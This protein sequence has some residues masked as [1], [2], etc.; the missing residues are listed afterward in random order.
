MGVNDQKLQLRKEALLSFESAIVDT[1]RRDLLSHNNKTD[2]PVKCIAEKRWESIQKK[3]KIIGITIGGIHYKRS[4]RKLVYTGN[5]KEETQ[6]KYA[7]FLK[8][9]WDK[10]IALRSEEKLR[11]FGIKKPIPA[12]FKLESPSTWKNFELVGDIQDLTYKHSVVSTAYS[13][14]TVQKEKY[15]NFKFAIYSHGTLGGIALV[16]EEEYT[17]MYKYDEELKILCKRIMEVIHSTYN[18]CLE[19]KKSYK[20]FC[21]SNKDFVN[22]LKGEANRYVEN[23]IKVRNKRD[24][25]SVD[26][27]GHNL[28]VVERIGNKNSPKHPAYVLIIRLYIS[29]KDGYNFLYSDS[30]MILNKIEEYLNGWM[31]GYLEALQCKELKVTEK[32]NVIPVDK[33]KIRVDVFISPTIEVTEAMDVNLY[34]WTKNEVSDDS[35]LGIYRKKFEKLG[36]QLR[37]NE[38]DLVYRY[39]EQVGPSPLLGYISLSVVQAIKNKNNLKILSLFS[40]TGLNECFLRGSS[41]EQLNIASIDKNPFPYN[42]KVSSAAHIVPADIFS[43]T[44]HYKKQP[45][46]EEPNDIYYGDYNLIIADPPHYLSMD[47]LSMDIGNKSTRNPLYA[48][49]KDSHAIFLLYFG[50]KEK[51]WMRLFISLLFSRAGWEEVYSILVADESFVLALPEKSV[52]HNESF[53]SDWT[54]ELEKA[55]LYSLYQITVFNK[56]FERIFPLRNLHQ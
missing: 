26:N 16:L 14:L 50:H 36:V 24:I 41:D 37:E 40:G 32:T 48:H 13:F 55:E 35:V 22:H 8:I 33:L 5:I 6:K 44:N 31:K 3:F 9:Y 15:E 51:E 10:H 45:P 17:D 18:F 4:D 39:S 19:Y 30:A 34:E 52:L 38:L 2:N 49:L 42:E 46:L 29:N 28:F 1:I 11:H 20:R 53:Q 7:D 56:F 23:M 54:G 21:I 43:L 12:G 25:V 27:I 47:F